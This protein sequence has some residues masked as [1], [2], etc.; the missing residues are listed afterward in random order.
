M[1][2]SGANKQICFSHNDC[3][4]TDSIGSLSLCSIF[5]ERILRLVAVLVDWSKQW[6]I[7]F[8]FS[9]ASSCA[10]VLFA[11]VHARSNLHGRRA[12]EAIVGNVGCVDGSIA[13]QTSHAAWGLRTS[14][15]AYGWLICGTCFYTACIACNFKLIS[16]IW[17]IVL[18][19][20]N[21]RHYPMTEWT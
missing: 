9:W 14:H 18:T 11:K 8:L 16:Q 3:T 5:H 1:S 6:Q 15:R 12:L 17:V 20:Y 13:F 21:Q 10:R 4:A 2:E 7:A 19:N